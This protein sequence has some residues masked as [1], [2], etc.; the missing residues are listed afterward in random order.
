ML[1]A[2]WELCQQAGR[3]LAVFGPTR[4]LFNRVYGEPNVMSLC[5]RALGSSRRCAGGAAPR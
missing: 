2:T 3:D 5:V 1:V 4:A